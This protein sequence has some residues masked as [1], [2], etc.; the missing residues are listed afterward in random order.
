MIRNNDYQN[1]NNISSIY[2]ARQVLREADCWIC[3]ADLYL[4]D[5]HVFRADLKESC[6]FGKMVDGY[7]SDWVF[8]LG[9]DQYITRVRKG[10][11]NRF[12]MVGISYLRKDDAAYVADAVERIYGTEGYETL[13]WDEVVD[14][15]LV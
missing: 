3:E 10:G 14:K 7:S 12:N 6:Y 5:E 2:A 1:V 13:F 9:E 4:F 11:T 15:K 8:E